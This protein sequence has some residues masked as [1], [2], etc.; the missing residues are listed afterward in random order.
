MIAINSL[1]LYDS[2]I[3][4]LIISTLVFGDNRFFCLGCQFLSIVLSLFIVLKQ[5]QLPEYIVKVLSWVSLFFLYCIF[6]IFW[7]SNANVTV[8]STSVAFAQSGC[9]LLTL[10][11]YGRTSERF[12]KIIKYTEISLM[13]ICLRFFLTVPASQWGLLRYST[14]KTFFNSNIIAMNIAYLS[15][16]LV[17]NYLYYNN[18]RN[19]IMGNRVIILLL[20]I[21]PMFIVLI[22]GTKKGIAIFALGLTIL[23]LSKSR[24]IIKSIFRLTIVAVLV[25]L[26]YLVLMNNPLFYQAIGR[27]FE[28][29]IS[30]FTGDS[31]TDGSTRARLHF[32][33]IAL[34]VFK[35]SPLF[36]VGNDGFR[37]LNNFEFTYSHNNY[38]EILANLGIIG[39]V[40]Y[41]SF[42]T[43]IIKKTIII[44]RE[45]ILPLCLFV[46]MLVADWGMVSYSV[47]SK[48]IW[49]FITIVPLY[50]PLK[51]LELK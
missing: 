43:G 25:Y 50:V 12:F 8:I 48:A 27:R 32:I 46:T 31:V 22:M 34:E 10:L 23:Y 18:N 14:E 42:F 41:Y 6:S 44:A 37:Y 28:L 4:L 36:G 1:T 20:C 19:T 45:N 33:E 17:W 39:F 30:G 11:I 9:I 47:E 15:I 21:V 29:M 13:L 26:L 49:M 3:L 51:I 38:T 7:A 24:N 40:I 16:I 5:K 35:S 2:S